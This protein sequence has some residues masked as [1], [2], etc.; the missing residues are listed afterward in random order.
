MDWIFPYAAALVTLLLLDAGWLFL[1][2]RKLYR[3]ELDIIRAKPNIVSATLFYLVYSVG[4]AAFALVPLSRHF[5]GAHATTQVL[6]QVFGW[7]AGLGV[8][9]YSTFTLTN[10]TVIEHWKLK[11]TILDTLW[12]GILTGTATLVGF[13]V[14]RALA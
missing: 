11:L 1:V 6:L 5:D 7:G 4:V 8:F 3:S 14:F 12:G 13:I 10:Q 2:A 9:A